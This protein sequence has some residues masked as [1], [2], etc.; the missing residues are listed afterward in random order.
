MLRAALAFFVLGLV[1][2]LFGAN[3]VAGLSIEVGRLLL[4]VFLIL[5]VISGLAYLI[6]GRSPRNLP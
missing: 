6:T 3:G 5:A 1:A 4:W 2:L